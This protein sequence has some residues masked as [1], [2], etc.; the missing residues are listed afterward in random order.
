MTEDE[1]RKEIEYELKREE[2]LPS[3][4][5]WDI[6]EPVRPLSDYPLR[7]ETPYPV[8]RGL[9]APLAKIFDVANLMLACGRDIP[10][11]RLKLRQL[12]CHRLVPEKKQRSMRKSAINP[13]IPSLHSLT[14]VAQK[15]RSRY[16]NTTAT[17]PKILPLTSLEKGSPP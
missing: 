1:P 8:P 3:E 12:T 4:I 15:N 11:K 6:S 9:T 16:G 10:G 5:F 17:I 13:A 14:P 2:E 7:H